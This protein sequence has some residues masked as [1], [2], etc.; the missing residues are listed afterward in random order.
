MASLKL[1]SATV[2]DVGCE[3]IAI[4]NALVATYDPHEYSNVLYEC[5]TI[6][7]MNGLLGCDPRRIGE[8]LDAI[9]CMKKLKIL[10]NWI[11]F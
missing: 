9:T 8:I 6:K 11:I 1:G 4:H 2:K 5:E 7:M 3:T 10:G